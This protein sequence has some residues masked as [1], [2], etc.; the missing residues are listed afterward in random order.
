MSPL[1]AIFTYVEVRNITVKV[2]Q[3]LY[4][5]TDQEVAI[6]TQR[7]DFQPV[8]DATSETIVG[9]GYNIAT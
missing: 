2:S 3:D 6:A 8:Q 1:S 4:M 9:L 7:L 5:E